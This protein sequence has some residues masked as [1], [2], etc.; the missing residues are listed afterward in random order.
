MKLVKKFSVLLL[1]VFSIFLFTNQI[2]L[3]D[4]VEG[5]P[6]GAACLKNPLGGID[7][8]QLLIG[9]IINA[10]LG[11]VGSLALLMFVYGGITWMTSS[12][13]A[14]KVKKGRDILVWSAIGLAI[15]FSAYGLTMVLIEGLSK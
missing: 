6:G 8:P 11:I 15:V 10:V 13:N 4:G 3:A 12:G 2:V 9:Q 7:T 1:L 14:D 5:C